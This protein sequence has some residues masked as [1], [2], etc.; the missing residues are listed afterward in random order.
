MGYSFTVHGLEWSS[1]TG[2]EVSGPM[3]SLVMV[4]AGRRPALGEL[5]GPGLATLKQRMQH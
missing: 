5:S 2:P 4:I 1:G 3:L